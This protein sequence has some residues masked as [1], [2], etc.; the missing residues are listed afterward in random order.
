MSL[1]DQAIAD[2]ESMRGVISNLALARAREDLWHERNPS[3]E[4]LYHRLWEQAV[5][6][7]KGRGEDPRTLRSRSVPGPLGGRIRALERKQ[8]DEI[9]AMPVTVRSMEFLTELR[10]LELSAEYPD[11]VHEPGILIVHVLFDVPGAPRP[12][13]ADIRL[14][15]D[16]LREAAPE[17]GRLEPAPL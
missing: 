16:V 1:H 10:T 3:E 5:E 2:A 6:E 15:Y 7:C 17:S 9:R 8:N 13:V 14:P 4:E 11:L 12:R